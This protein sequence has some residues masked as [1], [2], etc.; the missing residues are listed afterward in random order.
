[1][2]RLVKF[3]KL[4]A[5]CIEGAAYVSPSKEDGNGVL[6]ISNKLQAEHAILALR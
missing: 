2:V 4:D 3:L 6:D 5:E 1:M